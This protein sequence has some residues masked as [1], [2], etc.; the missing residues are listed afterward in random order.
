MDS[1]MS[2]VTINRTTVSFEYRFDAGMQ[3]VLTIVVDKMGIGTLP[4]IQSI[5]G[6]WLLS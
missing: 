1:L 2:L 6:I 3:A 4:L 5:L